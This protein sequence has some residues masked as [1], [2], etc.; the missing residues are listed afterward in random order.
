MVKAS[1]MGS[2]CSHGTSERG[3]A[4]EARGPTTIVEGITT[5]ELSL[6]EGAYTSAFWRKHW[7]ITEVQDP[8]FG[9]VWRLVLRGSEDR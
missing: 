2:G 8:S 1:K 4:V 7:N 6:G 9:S 5:F 3:T